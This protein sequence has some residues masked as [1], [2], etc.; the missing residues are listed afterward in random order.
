MWGTDCCSIGFTF[1]DAISN[2]QSN[3]D[4]KSIGFT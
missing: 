3:T 2:S 4:S 1:F